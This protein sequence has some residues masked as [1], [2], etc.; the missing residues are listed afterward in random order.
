MVKYSFSGHESFACK[1]L[2]LKK[3]YCDLVTL[4]QRKLNYGKSGESVLDALDSF[5]KICGLKPISFRIKTRAILPNLKNRLKS[6]CPA[7]QTLTSAPI[8]PF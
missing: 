8:C 6:F 4:L 7:T 3:D 1:S 5:Y 2:W